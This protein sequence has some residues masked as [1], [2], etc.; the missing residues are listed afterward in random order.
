M[1]VVCV[2]LDSVW[3]NKPANHDKALRLLDTVRPPKDSLIVL[4]EMF[5]T[6]FSMNAEVATDS[7]KNETY[8]F[9]SQLARDYS[10]NVM[11]GLVTTDVSGKG[12]NEC[13]VF[14]PDGSELARYCKLHPFTPGGELASY[15]KGEK[16]VTFDLQGFTV[17]PFIC[18]DLRFPE[19]FRLATQRGANLI[20][21]IASWPARR[22]QHW[23]KLLQARAIENQAYVIGVNRCGLDAENLA[24]DGQSMII[25]PSGEIVG[26][27]NHSEGTFSAEIHLAEV[28]EYRE[29]L[30]FLRD[31]RT[32]F[33]SNVR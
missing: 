28:L 24:H 23:V 11:G 18:Y 21:V 20:T 4:A 17:A 2:Q 3:E 30:P 10:A 8:N 22:H 33:F 12:R 14:S 9:L 15:V 19:A 26:Q 13:V 25:A 29:K 27:A 31:L 1:N 16:V 6:G 32:E 7:D 5:A